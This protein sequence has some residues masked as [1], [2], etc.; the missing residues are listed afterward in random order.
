[1]TYG[2]QV[3]QTRNSMYHLQGEH[4]VGVQERR[5]GRWLRKHP[6]LGQRLRGIID[7]AHSGLVPHA[8]AKIGGKLWFVVDGQDVLSSE[9][10]A[11]SSP[12]PED[13]FHYS[14][15]SDYRRRTDAFESARLPH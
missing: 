12:S 2:Y 8:A 9:I 10:T 5:S 11:L 7:Y 4:C 14:R 13:L 15:P 6:L 1:M 3:I